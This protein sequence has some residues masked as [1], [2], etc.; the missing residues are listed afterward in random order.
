MTSTRD[1]EYLERRLYR[2]ILLAAIGLSIVSIVGNA[3]AGF[4][5]RV[6]LKW[7]LLVVVAAVAYRVDV[8]LP[9]RRRGT[10][11]FYLFL[12]LVFFPFAFVQSGGSANNGMGYAFIILVTVTYLFKGV[13]RVVMSALLTAVYLAL[14]IVEHRVPELV[15]TYAAE[16]QF[17]DRLVQ[18]PLQ[19]LAVF[20]IVRRFSRAYD[21]AVGELRAQSVTD[22][23]TGLANRRHLQEVLNTEVA[24]ATRYGTP[25]TVMIADI[26]RFKDINDSFGHPAGDAVLVDFAARITSHTRAADVVGRWGGEEFMVI[27]AGSTAADGAHLAEKLRAV[28]G[29]TP[30]ETVGHVTTSFGVAALREAESA[31]RFVG[32]ADEALYR[33][34]QFGRNRVVTA[35]TS[36]E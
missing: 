13:P 23:L 16:S 22:S 6:S 31:E 14:L 19:F 28:I 10:G 26:D 2:T 36:D 3:V 33:A 1:P 18:V 30:F 4:P 12:I 34:K 24:Q 20:W 27:S 29:T 32:R 25:L 21:D 9:R 7:G 17:V 8:R 15:M 35:E 11:A 5:A